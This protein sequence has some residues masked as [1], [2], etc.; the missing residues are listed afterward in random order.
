LQDCQNVKVLKIFVECDPSDGIFT[1]FRHS[2]GFYERFSQDLLREVLLGVPTIKVVEF[3]AW[4]SVKREGDMIRGL[5][6]VVGQFR[7]KII[8]WGPE[9][10][11][12]ADD[13]KDWLDVTL[14]NMD[15]NV[16]ALPKE[17][18]SMENDVS[19][20]DLL[21]RGVKDLTVH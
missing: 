3:D 12:D 15:S 7:G 1:G 8:A 14:L 20:T 13:G 19:D 16:H 17:Q 21:I 11:W 18:N 6:Q 9:R 10:G 4:S 5:L 2:D